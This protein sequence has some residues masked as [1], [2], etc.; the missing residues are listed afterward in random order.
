VSNAISPVEL[1]AYYD[2]AGNE[3]DKYPYFITSIS[4]KTSGTLITICI[5]RVFTY[6]NPKLHTKKS[7][8]NYSHENNA[9]LTQ[10]Y[11]PQVEPHVSKPNNKLVIQ[12]A[13]W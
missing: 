7:E 2:Q 4:L 6:I 1:N 11:A 12:S 9:I 8:D 13:G 5:Y 3:T 10:S